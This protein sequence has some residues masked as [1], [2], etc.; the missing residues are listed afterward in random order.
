[1]ALNL[2]PKSVTA[3]S[4]Y[5]WRPPVRTGDVISSATLVVSGSAA[6]V[7]GIDTTEDSVHFFVSGGTLNDNAVIAATAVTAEGE[8]FT[9]TLLL[10]IRST[11][12][13]LGVI[14]AD[15]LSYALRPIVG[16]NRTAKPAELQDAR[17]NLNDI[18]AAWAEQGRE[19]GVKLPVADADV[20][21]VPDAYVSAIKANLRVRLCELYGAQPTRSDLINARNGQILITFQQLPADRAGTYF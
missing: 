21:F 19:L 1:M 17:E 6:T 20:L 16:L 12:R 4:R 13:E 15:V 10:P 18:L 11:G 9:E 2:E 5:T 3:V 7:S 8:T 14:V